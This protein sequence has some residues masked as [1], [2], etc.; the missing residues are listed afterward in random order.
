MTAPELRNAPPATIWLEEFSS[1]QVSELSD[2]DLRFLVDRYP[3]AVSASRDPV[4]GVP[5]LTASSWIGVITLP[6]G[7]EVRITTK[8]PVANAFY[9]LS[10]IHGWPF[11]PQELAA[12]APD[13]TI[14]SVVARFFRDQLVTI[15]SG[16]LYRRYAE[17]AENVMSIR[18]QIDFRA[19]LQRNLIQRQ[20]TACVFS[21]FT[22][23]IP[24]NQILRQTARLLADCGLLAELADD[25]GRIDY[26]WSDIRRTAYG[27]RHDTR[28]C[29]SPDEPALSGRPRA[30]ICPVAVALAR[31]RPR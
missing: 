17:Q 12:Y 1:A 10:V 3:R 14:L 9:M 18:G 19:D 29:L 8:V 31:G 21:E 13:A 15:E 11:R 30:G 27:G 24:E 25:F 20:R 28:L 6:S 4:A 22:R 16:G 23:D 5:R 7:S 2:E 26:R